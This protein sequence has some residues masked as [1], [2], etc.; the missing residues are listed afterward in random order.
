MGGVSLY[1][2]NRTIRVLFIECLLLGAFG[3]HMVSSAPAQDRA[4]FEAIGLGTGFPLDEL[5]KQLASRRVVFVGEIH[6]RYDHHLNQLEIIRQVRQLDSNLAIGVEYFQQPFQKQV[7]DY[8]AERISE[9]DLLRAT[10][11]YVRWGYDYRLYAPIFRYARE[12]HIPVIALNVPTALVRAVARVGIAGLSEN[13]RHGLP[14]SMEPVSEEY[15]NRLQEIFMAHQGAGP[16]VFSHFV[17]AQQVWDEGMA[18]S[19]ATYLSANKDRHLVILA[20]TGHM[21]FGS[22][23]PKCLERRIHAPYAVVLSSGEN[24]EPHMADYLLLSKKQDLPPAGVLSALLEEKDGECRIGAVM[25]FGGAENAGLKN[26]DVLTAIDGQH[27]KTS[28]DVQLALWNKK[29]GEIVQVE[30]YRKRLFRSARPFSLQVKLTGHH[31]VLG[32]PPGSPGSA[33]GEMTKP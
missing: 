15:R 17:E 20:G 21:E 28:A 24:I 2:A 22:G 33:P 25:P 31:A 26:G 19:A 4:S 7:D 13:E 8:I 16:S 12:Q 3:F 23:I 1:A 27:V 9:T 10:E 18:E 32:P 11:Y 5:A 6:N 14:G 30:G 29:P